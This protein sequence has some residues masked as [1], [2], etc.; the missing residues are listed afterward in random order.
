MEVNLKKR[1]FMMAMNVGF[2]KTLWFSQGKRKQDEGRVV[3][4]GICGAISSEL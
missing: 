2:S 3:T 4:S 1:L